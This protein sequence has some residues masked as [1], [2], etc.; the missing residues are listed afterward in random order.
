MSRL[1]LVGLGAVAALA[2]CSNQGAPGQGLPPATEWNAPVA[3]SEESDPGMASPSGMANPHGMDDPHAGLDM[4]GMEGFGDD[5]LPLPPPDPNRAIDP[6]KYLRGVIVVGDAVKGKLNPEHPVFLS[7][8]PWSPAIQAAA[9]PTLAVDKLAH[10][11]LPA[12]FELTEA[13]AMADGTQ[14]AGQVVITAHVSQTGDA[15]ARVPGDL[16]GT[17]VATIPADQIELV[18]DTVIE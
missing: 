17:A 5:L 8:K 4:G 13:N 14:F 2:A 11:R 12:A 18:V 10:A 1:L 7:V 6:S 16:I 9:G 3:A 15:L